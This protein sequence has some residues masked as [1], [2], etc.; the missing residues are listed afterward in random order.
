M[1]T[2]VPNVLVVVKN[3]EV[4]DVLADSLVN[5]CVKDVDVLTSALVCEGSDVIVEHNNNPFSTPVQL[6]GT[7]QLNEDAKFTE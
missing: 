7:E 2:R 5:V 6:I 4:V 3:G 1:A